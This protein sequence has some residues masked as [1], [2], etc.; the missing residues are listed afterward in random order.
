MA[1]AQELYGTS[2]C[3][4][5]SFVARWLQPSREWKEEV[6]EAV[7]NV[8]QFLRQESF[9]GERWL[10][11]QEVRVLKVIKVRLPPLPPAR[12][13]KTPGE[14]TTSLIMRESLSASLS[15]THAADLSGHHI[16]PVPTSAYCTC[17]GAGPV[18]EGPAAGW[19]NPLLWVVSS[20]RT[21]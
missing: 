20:S 14:K 9:H 11:N 21:L 13:D 18:S 5:D 3:R 19:S 10:Q 15:L 1:L 7:A 12:Q 4:L 8:E 2:S 16:Q 17:S 6:L